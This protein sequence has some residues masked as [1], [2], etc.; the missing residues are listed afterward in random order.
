MDLKLE[1]IVIPVADVDRAKDFYVGLGFRL[2]ADFATDDGFRVVQVTPPGSPASIIFG[3][4]VTSAEPGSVQGLHV[5]VDDI[6]AAREELAAHGAAVSEVWHDATGVFHRA[7]TA[8]R[9]PGPHPERASYGSF[10]SFQ[11]TE[12]NG[13]T[14]QEIT[15]RLPG[16]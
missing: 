9:V 5:I 4:G 15:T 8:N 14:V 11:D 2:D 7:G 13:W 12:G 16:R 10:L 1:L 6:E 3:D